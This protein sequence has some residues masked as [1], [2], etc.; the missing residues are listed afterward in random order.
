MI[1]AL[2][3]ISIIFAKTGRIFEATDIA[4]FICTAD[5][6][7][8]SRDRNDDEV[9]WRFKHHNFFQN[10]HNIGALYVGFDAFK[11]GDD[12]VSGFAIRY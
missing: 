11:A 8:S 9:D 4:D 6:C 1:P 2:Q 3:W 12:L 7:K 10:L 5:C